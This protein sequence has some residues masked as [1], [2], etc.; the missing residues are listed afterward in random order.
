[1]TQH[2]AEPAA[3]AET[4]RVSR[5]R[6]NAIMVATRRVASN[7]GGL[8]LLDQGI[9][10]G[11]NFVTS[12]IVG[13]YLGKENLGILFITL[14]MYTVLQCITD[15]LVHTPYLV[16][17]PHFNGQRS[18]GYTGSVLAH[19]AL[20]T[21]LAIGLIAVTAVGMG[22]TDSANGPL[23][24]S[25]LLL[26]ILLP[27]MMLREFIHSLLHNQLRQAEAVLLDGAVAAVQ[28]VALLL[29]WWNES[30]TVGHTLI[31]IGGASALVGAFWLPRLIRNV[32]VTLNLIASDFRHNW[33]IGRWTLGSYLVGSSAP[34]VLP[35]LLAITHGTQATG[36]LAACLTLIGLAQTF[37]R[38]LGKYMAPQMSVS[39]AQ[40]GSVALRKTVQTFLVYALSVVTLMALVLGIGGQWLVQLVYG[41]EYDDV[42]RVMQCLALGCWVQTIDI[43]VGNGLLAVALSNR[44]FWA[45]CVRCAVTAGLAFLVIPRLGPLGVAIALVVGMVAGLAIRIPCLLTALA[46][47]PERSSPELQALLGS[48]EISSVEQDVEQDVTGVGEISPVVS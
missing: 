2:L 41:S 24:S 27:G 47:L 32:K 39:Y 23:A 40:G 11:T 19:A 46:Q 20:L 9:V 34:T 35:W 8:A 28:L 13:R 17:A 43:V 21:L 10:S 29:W 6:R 26:T 37:L 33:K 30:L 48:S 25:M 7:R 44:N 1:M 45:D 18:K 12:L 31:A 3:C 38:G 42:S 4:V 22:L 15:Q 16:R 36:L 5:T 14:S